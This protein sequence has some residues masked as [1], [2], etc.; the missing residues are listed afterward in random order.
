MD[1]YLDLYCLTLLYDSVTIENMKKKIIQDN[2]VVIYQ[3]KTGAIELQG[4]FMNET[5]WATQAQ[6]VEIF[7]TE[8][9]VITKHIGNILKNKEI[10]EKSNVQKM[11]I[12]NSDKPVFFY[13]LDMIL[14]VGYRANSAKAIAFR[15]WAT[16]TLRQYITKGY[17]INPAV[18]KKNYAEFQKAIENIKHLLPAGAAIDH[19]S[20]LELISAFADTWLSLDAYDKDILPKHGITKR[21]VALTANQLEATL[22]SFKSSL[23]KKGEATDIFGVARNADAVSGIV[24]NVMQS[25]G[26]KSVYPTV[27]EKA[28]HLLYFIVKNHPFIDG[29]KRSG[30]YSFVWFLDK[31]GILDRSKMTPPALTAI[32]L[33]IAESDPKHKERMIHLILQLLK[34]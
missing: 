26:G 6:I 27:E 1:Y 30:A 20:V 11:H 9:S 33:F 3:S 28:A 22:V 14:A 4:D 23:V 32:T 24:G 5:I 2:Q 19:A 31:A 15:R 18:V 21:S 12:A 10:D 7:D 29:N 25:F 34:K 8:R 16:K 13:S 17:A